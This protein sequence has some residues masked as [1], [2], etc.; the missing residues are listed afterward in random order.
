M[1]RPLFGWLF[2]LIALLLGAPLL[3]LLGQ[4]RSLEPMPDLVYLDQLFAVLIAS[5]GLAG[6]LIAFLLQLTGRILVALALLVPAIALCAWHLTHTHLGPVSPTTEQYEWLLAGLAVYAL[7]LAGINWVNRGESGTRKALHY[8]GITL[9][10]PWCLA[11]LYL[12]RLYY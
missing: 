11:L 6:L 8:L 10:L 12:G 7:V 5:T 2:C 4:P 1:A 9:L 3:R